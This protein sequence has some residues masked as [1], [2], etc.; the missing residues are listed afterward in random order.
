MAVCV[1][2]LAPLCPAQNGASKDSPALNPSAPPAAAMASLTGVVMDENSAVIPGASVTVKDALRKTQKETVTASDGTFSVTELWPGSY[3]VTVRREGFSTA[4][5]K[6]VLL[7]AGEQAALK[8]RLRVG[9]IGETVSVTAD[10][11]LMANSG[12]PGV[13]LERQAIENFPVNGRSLQTLTLLAPGTVATRAT[14]TEQGQL[15]VNGQRA[16]ANYFLLDGVSANIG[17][18]AGA[19]GTGQSGAGSLPGMSAMGSTNTLVTLDSLQEFKILTTAFAPEFG[20][21]P[22]AQIILTTRAGTNQF[23]GSFF[24]YFRSSALGARDWFDS[25]EHASLPSSR[26]HDFGGVIG[27]PV[28]KD[29]TFFFLSYEGLRAQLPQFAVRDVPSMF[30]RENARPELRPILNAFPLPNRFDGD[31]LALSQ[32]SSAY[33]DSARFDAASLRLDQKFGER[34]TF[35]ARYNYAPSEL[36]QRGA[37]SSLSDALRLSFRTQTAT[38]GATQIITPRLVNDF[39][40]NYSRSTGEKFFTLDDFG[41]AVPVTDATIFPSFASSGNAFF[42]F[43][44]GDDSTS[45]FSGKDASSLQKQ[46]NVLD[47]VA[48]TLG[49]HQLKVGFDYRRLTSTYEEWKYRENAALVANMTDLQ[50]GSASS[51]IVSAQDRTV[52]NFTNLSVYAQDTWR[53]SQR[54]SLTYGVRWEYNPPP[55]AANGQSLFTVTGLDNL[56][57][58]NLA[59]EGTPLYQATRNN[60]AP[61]VGAAFQLFKHP[62]FETMLRG[63]FGVF[64]DLGSGPLGNSSS[65]FPYQ[66]RKTFSNV[67]YPLDII[68]TTQLPYNQSLPVSLIRVAEPNLQ[69]PRV[70]QWNFGVEQS[71]GAKQTLTATYV[72]VAGRRLLRTELLQNP[73]PYFEQVYVTTNKATSDYHALQLQFQRRLAQG[74]QA[75][76]SYTWAHA[77]D[78]ASNDSTASLPTLAGREP[79]D[80]LLDRGPSDFDIRHSLTAAVSYDLPSLFK[81]GIGRAVF[82][83]WSVETIFSAHSAA[84]VEVFSRRISDFGI[85]NLRPD[86]TTDV[87]LYLSDPSAPGG[88]RFNPAAFLVPLYEGQGNLGRNALRGFPFTQ[89]DFAVHRNFALTDRVGLQ[90]RMEIFNLF[91]HPNFASPVGD[92]DSAN[93]GRATTML[94][95]SLTATNNTGFNPLFQEGGPRAVQFSLKLQF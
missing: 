11:L 55:V 34:W 52:I 64:Y 60:Y 74:F 58:L 28:I 9:D 70:M 65:S 89:L 72:G 31:N 12:S 25:T 80:A 91:N 24:E 59:P 61:R 93:F 16:N 71:L 22:G 23:H 57:N 41:G 75:Y 42:G 17:V 37:G 66:R 29:R 5:V 13:T 94:G 4:E 88:R 83:R 32:F 27:G 69:L 43:N 53:I 84:P 6:D 73:T 26:T 15:S 8:V 10:P 50:V 62:G 18:A 30:A 92:L 44:L 7:S 54:L 95:R 78:I 87:P 49:S 39:R 47:N 14:F 51:V 46:F 68:Y 90:F 77:I 56:A 81:S 40:V 3:I 2:L 45:L 20:R 36:F 76:A 35:F 1:M 38:L 85:V 86:V 67:L 82:S 21:T 19:S 33:T 63:G 48:L 79:Y